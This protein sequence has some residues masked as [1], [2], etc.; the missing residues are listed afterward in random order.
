MEMVMMVLSLWTIV[1]NF[2]LTFF[3]EPTTLNFD[4]ISSQTMGSGHMLV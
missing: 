4:R 2:N 3:S 1:R